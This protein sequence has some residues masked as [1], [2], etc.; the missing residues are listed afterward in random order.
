M[1]NTIIRGGLVLLLM[2]GFW[3]E[4]RSQSKKK[5]VQGLCLTVRWL[6]GN[7]MPSPE[8]PRSLGRLVN[9]EVWIYALTHTSQATQTPEGFYTEIKTK[10]VRVVRT[11]TDGKVCVSLPT[12]EYSIFIKEDKGLYANIFDGENNISPV[13]VERYKIARTPIDIS[14]QAVF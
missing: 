8:Q 9:R 3:S 13:K 11:G 7:Q 12:G 14:Y 2:G 10:L 5:F 1:L 6:E 4:G